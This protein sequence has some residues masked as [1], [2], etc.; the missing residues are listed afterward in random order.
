MLVTEK[1]AA[2]IAC[3]EARVHS[4]D[5]KIGINAYAGHAVGKGLV[6]QPLMMC[7]GSKCMAWRW[8]EHETTV[9]GKK[10]P[11]RRGYCGN[12]GRAMW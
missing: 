9:T 7:L 10:K 12:A 2:E 5:G 11:D 3:M 1:K 6:I 4:A 8:A